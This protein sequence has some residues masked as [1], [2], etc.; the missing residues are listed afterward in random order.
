MERRFRTGDRVTLD[1]PMHPRME[2][3]AGNGVN[4]RRGPL[5]FSVDIAEKARKVTGQMKTS[6]DF[7]AWDITPASPWNYALASDT[8][9]EVEERPVGAM[10]WLASETPVRLRLKA[11]EVPS[12]TA[13]KTTPALPALGFAVTSEATPIEMIPSGSTRIRLTTLPVKK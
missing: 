8:E 13:G 7:P 9:I 1:L 4:V 10:P 11:Y 2:Y 12:W 6:E 5:L 3:T